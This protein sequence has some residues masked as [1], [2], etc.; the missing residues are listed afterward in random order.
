MLWH[1]KRE[2]WLVL[3]TLAALGACSPDQHLTGPRKSI[4]TV[5]EDRDTGEA[6][7]DEAQWSPWST[8]QNLGSAINTGANEQHPAI[9]KD[10]L[11]LYFASDRPGGFGGLDIWVS[12]RETL[13][14]PWGPPQNLG[15]NINS[16]GNDLAPSFTR[17]GH[18]MYFHSFGRGG[19]GGAD[20][21]LSRRHD[22]HDNLGWQEAE[23]LGC[24][25]NSASDDAGPTIFQDGATGITTLYFTSKRPGGPGDFDIYA[26]TRG[27]DDSEFGPAVLIPELSGPFRDTRTSISR[28]GL[29]LFLSSDVTGRTGGIGGQDLWVSSRATIT[30]TW[31]TPANLGAGVN[32]PAF[33]GAPALSFDGTTLYFFSNRAGG[34]GNNDLMVTTRTKLHD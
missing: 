6:D 1:T 9:S 2:R 29:T 10:G 34:F 19:C 27:E 21:F 16:S 20:L 3:A 15:S 7:R 22:K 8:P 5:R 33:D 26:S 4:S 13:D 32:T 17:D 24:V 14:D 25:V 31:S 28:D 18:T 23:N 11:S 30:D 12:E